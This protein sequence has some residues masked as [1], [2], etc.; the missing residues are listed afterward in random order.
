M[1]RFPVG[2]ADHVLRDPEQ[3]A[4]SSDPVAAQLRQ[5]RLTSLGGPSRS[6]GT[7]YFLGAALVVLLALGG[8]VEAGPKGLGG[9]GAPSSPPGFN[10]SQVSGQTGHNGFDTDGASSTPRGWGEGK[11][12]W[13]TDSATTTNPD[14]AVLPPGFS[15]H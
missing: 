2:L 14:P 12:D 9:G 3:I 6:N 13:K 15:K 8:A 5:P 10:G 7:S 4:Q 1:E 11:A